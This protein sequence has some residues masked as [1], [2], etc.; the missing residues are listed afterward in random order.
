MTTMSPVQEEMEQRTGQKEKI[1]EYSEHM[2]PVFGH[3]E[4]SKDR[5]KGDKDGPS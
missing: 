2:R 1:G 5:K 3:E 4:K